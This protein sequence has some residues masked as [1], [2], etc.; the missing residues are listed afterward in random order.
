MMPM[1]LLLLVVV[2]F[3]AGAHFKPGKKEEEEEDTSRQ[4]RGLE[5]AGHFRWLLTEFC[6]VA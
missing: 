6:L 3:V 4:A 5:L 2:D 1:S